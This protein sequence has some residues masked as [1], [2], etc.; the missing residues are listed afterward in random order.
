MP[1]ATR[2]SAA[3]PAAS[4]RR[5]GA[6]PRRSRAAVALA[7][8]L[9]AACAA[10]VPALLGGSAQRSAT[11]PAAVAAVSPAQAAS[12]AILR[13]PLRASDAFAPLHAGAGPL[14]A[15]PDLARTLREPRGGL[16]AGLVSVVP[17][18]SA[19]CLRVPFTD[20]AAQWWCQGLARARAGNL[21]L[22]LRPPGALSAG[23]VQ[24]LVG[25]VPDGVRSVTVI[26]AG[27]ARVV[28][29]RDNV[30]DVALIA[31][32]TVSMVIP[33]LGPRRYRAP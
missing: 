12:F 9:I 7:C 14:G 15:N 25:L 32:R 28:R 26:T 22:A 21:I 6:D 23:G 8:F 19:V 20:G 4:R 1:V 24:V 31:P 13:R 33:G 29:V 16:S 18:S 3:A 30:Y 10:A 5:A 27:A 2:T 17:A 11:P